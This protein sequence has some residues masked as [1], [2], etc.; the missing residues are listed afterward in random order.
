MKPA[1]EEYK[2]TEHISGYMPF[3][4]TRKHCSCATK[5]HDKNKHAPLIVFRE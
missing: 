4:A 3:K 1:I 5:E 2:E